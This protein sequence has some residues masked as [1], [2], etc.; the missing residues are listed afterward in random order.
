MMTIV[1]MMM[2]CECFVFCDKL[3]C[4]LRVLDEAGSKGFSITPLLCR[5]TFRNDVGLW[6]CARHSTTASGIESS[7]PRYMHARIYS[8]VWD[9]KIA[10]MRDC[11]NA[12]LQESLLHSWSRGF[13]CNLAISQSRIPTLRD[14]ENA[15]LRDCEIARESST[16]RM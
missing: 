9:C 3:K 6:Q 1:M 8:C 15:R 5:E 13:S 2:P 4:G 14:C 10:R 7:L 12:R 11:E 16:P